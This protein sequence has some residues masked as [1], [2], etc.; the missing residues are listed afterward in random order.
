VVQT[1]EPVGCNLVR[2]Y[3]TWQFRI[4]D[5]ANIKIREAVVQGRHPH[6]MAVDSVYRQR[7]HHALHH[8]FFANIEANKLSRRSVS[9]TYITLASSLAPAVV[10]SLSSYASSV[11][12]ACCLLYL[13]SPARD[14][15]SVT[16]KQ[17]DNLPSLVRGYLDDRVEL[18]GMDYQPEER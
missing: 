1:V 2:S 17:R 11:S 5:I 4:L 10:R 12:R 6:A 7:T 14:L 15:V 9:V 3:R 16:D 13:A 18:L 8:A